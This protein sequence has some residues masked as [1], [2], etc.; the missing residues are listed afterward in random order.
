MPIYSLDLR[1]ISRSQNRSIVAAAAYRTGTKIEDKRNQLV[2]DYTRKKGVART[3]LVCRDNRGN[4]EYPRS[5]FAG[6]LWN[7]AELSEKRSN[8]VLGRE[9]VVALPA[10]FT[11]RQCERVSQKLAE[12]LVTTLGVAAMLAVHDPDRKTDGRNKHLHLLFSSRRV[13]FDWQR[14]AFDFGEKTRELDDRARGAEI[15][16]AIRVKWEQLANEEL[17]SAGL[18]IDCRS[19]QDR[20]I[21]RPARVHLGHQAAAMERKGRRTRAGDHNRAVDELE[22]AEIALAKATAARIAAEEA[23]AKARAAADQAKPIEPPRQAIKLPD[24]PRKAPEPPAAPISSAP[25]WTPYRPPEPTK[26]PVSPPLPAQP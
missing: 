2:F 10:E 7:G 26:Q 3:M 4:L 19:L 21:E 25:T 18:S 12:Y 17:Q 6:K 1:T 13:E 5:D 9:L 15:I 16:K 24:P 22:A 20:G 11:A 23:E 8:S 14:G